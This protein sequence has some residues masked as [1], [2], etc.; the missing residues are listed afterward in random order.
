M[1][2]VQ[3]DSETVEKALFEHPFHSQILI[4]SGTALLMDE[5]AYVLIMIF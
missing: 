1:S 4:F 3:I 2:N 5:K